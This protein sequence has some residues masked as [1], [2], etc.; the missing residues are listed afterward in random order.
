MYV[1]IDPA[2]YRTTLDGYSAVVVDIVRCQVVA[3]V[4]HINLL[5]KPITS[6][7]TMTMTIPHR[8]LCCQHSVFT[9]YSHSHTQV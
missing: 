1:A 5:C 9:V 4:I 6:H 3:K 8:L 7:S 2:P